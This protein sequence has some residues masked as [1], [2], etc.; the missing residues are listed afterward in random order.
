M[1]LFF[2]YVYFLFSAKD[3]DK[4]IAHIKYSTM[5]MISKTIPA[6][7]LGKIATKMLKSNRIGKYEPSQREV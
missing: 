1:L 7:R 4:S 2:V 3:K 6:K 5:T